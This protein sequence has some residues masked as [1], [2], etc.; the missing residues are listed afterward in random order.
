LKFSSFPIAEK[1]F[2]E[3]GEPYKKGFAEFAERYKKRGNPKL[4]GGICRF[5]RTYKKELPNL[6]NAIKKST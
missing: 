3:F 2:G 1:G 6:P 4:E 5:C